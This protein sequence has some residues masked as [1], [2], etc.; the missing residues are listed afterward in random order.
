MEES[1]IA[2]HMANGHFNVFRQLWPNRH[3]ALNANVIMAFVARKGH[4]AI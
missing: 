3:L 1:T 2:V 4:S